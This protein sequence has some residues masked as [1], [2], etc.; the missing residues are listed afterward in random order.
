MPLLDFWKVN[1][2]YTPLPPC[3]T[4]APLHSV[5]SWSPCSHIFCM[6]HSR[7][8]GS[9]RRLQTGWVNQAAPDWLGQSGGSRRAG[10]IRRL[11]T[12]WVNQAAPD[13]LGQSGGSR[14]AGSIRRLQTGWVNQAAPDWLGQSGGSRLAGSIRRL[15][16]G[17]V[18]QAAPD[19]LG[20]SGGSRRAGSIRR[21]CVVVSGNGYSVKTTIATLLSVPV[22]CY[23]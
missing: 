8:A 12:G 21:W 19:W 10:S 20:Q 22:C 9:I 1:T 13:W 11:Q 4:F 3:P 14:R 18:N 15:Q 23:V 7:R 6:Q 17:W 16:P 5:N 2:S